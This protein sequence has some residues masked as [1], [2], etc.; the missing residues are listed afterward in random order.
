MDLKLLLQI[1][2][3][4][5][6]LLYLYL[7]YRANIWLWV[8][9]LI[10]PVVHGV[11][12][13]KSGLYADFSM[14]MY[15]ILAG[16]YGLAR[17]SHKPKGQESVL[18]IDFTPK[19]LWPLIVVVYGALHVAIYWFLTTF[20]DSTVPFWD[21]FTTA[22]CVVAYWLLSR[23]Y[24]EQ[25]LVWLVVDVTTVALYIYKDIPLTAALYALYS[26]LAVVGYR[27]WLKEIATK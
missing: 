18:K 15:Y 6:G 25:W 7:E 27:R 22:L 9:G 16:L 4:A 3:V 19:G 20:T 17:W 24:V 5:L 8:V 12:Y 10:M 13:Y 23:K 21:S 14:Q 2:G 11:L 26:V 1:V